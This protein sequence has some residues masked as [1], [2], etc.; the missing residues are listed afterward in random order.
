MNQKLWTKNFVLVA[1]TNF[2]VYIVYY[3][4]IVI[5]AKHASTVMNAAPWEAGLASGIFFVGSMVARTISGRVISLFGDKRVMIFG[6]L[7][8]LAATLLY[9]PVTGISGLLIVRTLHGVGF[10]ISATSTSAFVARIVPVSR[11]GEGISY[12]ALSMTLASAIGPFAGMAISHNG[13]FNTI[14]FLSVASVLGCCAIAPFLRG[15]GAPAAPADSRAEGPQKGAQE[16]RPKSSIHDFFEV[17][18]LPVSIL[19]VLIVFAYVSVL[20]FLASFADTK[21]L[22]YASEWFFAVFSLFA[23]AVRP[24]TGR[25]FDRRGENV[26]IY[27]SIVLFAAG[28]MTLSLAHTGFILLCAAALIGLGYGTFFPTA[29]AIVIKYAPRS[30]VHLATSTYFIFSDLGVA[31]GPFIQGFIIPV[32]GYRGLYVVMAVFTL[33]LVFVY[34]AIHG[35]KA[36]RMKRNAT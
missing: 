8:Y 21:E 28:L 1:L 7:I 4:L 24:I 12:Y 33:V 30:R 6:L 31:V 15:P 5:I 9:F 29:N 10:G 34:F 27:P 19:C 16:A 22:Q 17:S 26:V 32:T 14:L 23:L 11:Q 3:I 25:I 35:R 13:S 20:S 18:A 2:L 36:A